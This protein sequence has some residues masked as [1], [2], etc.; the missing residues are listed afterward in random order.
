MALFGRPF[1]NPRNGEDEDHRI[2][3]LVSYG[4]ADDGAPARVLRLWGELLERLHLE[5]ATR[6]RLDQRG[7]GESGD[8]GGGRGGERKRRRRDRDR[9]RDQPGGRGAIVG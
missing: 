9:D 6:Q 4:E 1:P 8:G 5:Q 3:L 7:G 2:H